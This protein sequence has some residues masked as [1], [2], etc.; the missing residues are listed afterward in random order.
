MLA[1]K[2]VKPKLAEALSDDVA[3]TTGKNRTKKSVDRSLKWLDLCL[4]IPILEETHLLAVVGGGK[5]EY[6]RK[7]SATESAKRDVA[8]FVL[9]GFGTGEDPK[10]RPELL[11]MSINELPE[12]KP[13][14]IN[15]IESPLEIL[16][17]IGSGI[18]MIH[19]AY[20][21]RMA[22]EGLAIR[23][24]PGENDSFSTWVT[25]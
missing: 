19:S 3:M 15:G 17:A 22:K 12:N 2:E 5:D 13:R 6:L 1:I 8:G 18:D 14:I 10:D 11:Q 9:G 4:Q 21:Y 23:F 24:W 7:H 25:F 20:P 16:Q